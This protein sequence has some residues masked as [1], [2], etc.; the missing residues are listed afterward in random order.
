MVGFVVD[1]INPTDSEIMKDYDKFYQGNLQIYKESV[2]QEMHKKLTNKYKI[3]VD[4]KAILDAIFNRQGIDN[5]LG[6]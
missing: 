5:S 1:I 2:L 6:E 3:I 4:Q